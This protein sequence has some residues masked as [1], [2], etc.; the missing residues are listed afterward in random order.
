MIKVTVAGHLT[1]L[2]GFL[3]NSSYP[4]CRSMDFRDEGR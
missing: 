4:F 3:G 1:D 2:F